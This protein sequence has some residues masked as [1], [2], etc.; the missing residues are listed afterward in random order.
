MAMITKILENSAEKKIGWSNCKIRGIE[1]NESNGSDAH[2]KSIED[3]VIKGQ[4][5]NKGGRK[6]RLFVDCS[7]H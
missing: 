7:V 6:N 2:K 1:N 4:V 3:I 5:Q